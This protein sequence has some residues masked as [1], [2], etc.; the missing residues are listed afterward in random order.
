M[1]ARFL[2]NALRLPAAGQVIPADLLLDVRESERHARDRRLHLKTTVVPRLRVGGFA[3]LA[4]VAAMHN[5]LVFGEVAWTGWFRLTVLLGGYAAGTWYALHILYADLRPRLDLGVAF[6]VTDFFIFA[7]VLHFTGADRSWLFLLPLVRV[8]DQVLVSPGRT[9]VFAHLAPCCYLLVVGYVALVEGRAV[10]VGVEAAKVAVIY[11]GGWYAVAVSVV[12]ADRLAGMTSA[13]RG[14][15]SLAA[16][17]TRQVNAVSAGAAE[18]RTSLDE[19]KRLAREQAE[20]LAAS[21]RD[22]LRQAQILDSASDGIVFVSI[23]GRIE[24]A[25]ARAGVLLGFDPASVIGLEMVS[26][27]S[28]LYAVGQGDSFLPTLH[29]LLEDPWGGGE[30]DLQQPASGRVF[31][32]V[33]QPARDAEGRCAGLTFTFQ[34]VTRARDLV[35]QFEDKSRLLEDASARSAEASRAKS[36]FLAHMTHEIRTPLSA[37]IGTVEQMLEERPDETRLQRIRASSEGLM[38][39]IGDVL[40][41]SKI[42]SRKL[43]LDMTAFELRETLADVVETLR[44]NADDKRLDL[45]LGI[46]EDVPDVLVGDSLRLRQ[47]LMNLV[48]NAVKFTEA[49]QVRVSVH[50]AQQLPGEVCL[51]FSVAD[52]GVGIPRDKQQQVFDAFTQAAQPVA[53]RY[54]GTGLGLSISARLV[55]LMG[56]DIWVESDV[57][58]GSTFRFTTMLRLPGAAATETPAAP[59]DGPRREPRTVLVVEDETIHRELLSALLLGRGHRVITARNG[60]EALVELSR[61]RI[62]IALMDLRMPELDGIGAATT[63][64]AWERARG[65]RLPLVAMTASALA[66]DPERCMAAGMDRFLT[67]PIRREVLFSA[68]EELAGVTAPGDVPP[69]LAGRP[70][71]VAGLGS[72]VVLARKLVDLFLEQSPTLLERVRGA[73]AAGDADEL[74]TAALA[75]KGMVSN[76]PPGPA[77][78]AAARMETIGFDADFPAAQEAYPL[79][80]REVERLRELLPALV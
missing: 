25:N 15:R 18:L 16:A 33:A 32:W 12:A 28:R 31:H 59:A 39:L 3:L 53:P 27:V 71:F 23:A 7:F 1:V 67:K 68:V 77:R 10:P 49:G 56:G 29:A 8:M 22:R 19:Q 4:V 73:I 50:L 45:T 64:R 76:F 75:L 11:A 79:L 17:L 58:S 5:Q 52:T 44:V 34:D 9:L 74:R 41:L 21:Q 63:I 35:R 46:G 55:E 13:F 60:R 48:G 20:G 36:E 78:G 80:E 72:D 65:G 54:R 24:A 69:E 40:D 51:H 70:A 66:G 38:A 37:I 2:R 30:G 14:A 57:G 26:L 6:L 61:H 47:I 62:D 42:E 43:R